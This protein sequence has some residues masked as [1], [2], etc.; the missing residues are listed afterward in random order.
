MCVVSDTY[1]DGGGGVGGRGLCVTEGDGGGDV[2]DKNT[3]QLN[4]SLVTFIKP[5]ECITEVS[6]LRCRSPF[7]PV[8]STVSS[9]LSPHLFPLAHADAYMLMH[10]C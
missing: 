6:S 4:G 3:L 8:L 7:H 9:H 10:T 2:S 1:D 5:V